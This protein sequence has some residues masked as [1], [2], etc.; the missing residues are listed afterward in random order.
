MSTIGQRRKHILD[1]IRK[2][3]FVKV[4]ELAD[5]LPRFRCIVN[6]APAMIL[7]PEMAN[8][9]R[10]DCFCLD[11]ASVKSIPGDRV[12]HARGL[13]GRYKPE[14]SGKLIAD[15]ILRHMGGM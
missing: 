14:S 1:H 12:L 7:S 4:S 5:A 10:S 11:L 9:I 3:G 2:D 6:T 8:L 13:P 15:T